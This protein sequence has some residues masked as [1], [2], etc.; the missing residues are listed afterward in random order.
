MITYSFIN[1]RIRLKIFDSN[2]AGNTISVCNAVLQLFISFLFL[3]LSITTASTAIGDSLKFEPWITFE[4]EY[5][6]NVLFGTKNTKDDNITTFSPAFSVKKKTARLNGDITAAVDAVFYQ[7]LDELDAVDKRSSASLSY[8]FTERLQLEMTGGYLEDSRT[9]R[10]VGETGLVFAGDR[11][12]I[13]GGL[14]G[15]YQLSEV[16]AVGISTGYLKEDIDSS[17]QWSYAAHNEQNDTFRANLSFSK[18]ISKLIRNT[19]ALLDISYM[20]YQSESPSLQLIAYSDLPEEILVIIADPEAGTYP[21]IW[22]KSLSESEYDVWNISAGFSKEMT[23]RLSFFIRSGASCVMSDEISTLA[24]ISSD[25]TLYDASYPF[26]GGTTWGWLLFSGVSYKGTYDRIDA[27]ISRDI[28]TASGLNGTTERSGV[29]LKYT[30]SITEKLSARLS[31]SF[32]LNQSDR[33]SRSDID[34][35]TINGGAGMTYNISTVWKGSI[36]WNYTNV[37]ERESDISK[38]R[39]R[40]YA[41]II[42]IFEL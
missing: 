11:E 25:T 8:L 19:S 3:F 22:R 17:D 41:R 13:R 24:I 35:L 1:S 5:S 40:V 21:E 29:S 30:R 38:E 9:D 36:D 26:D 15:Q 42:K 23:E 28:Q 10:E 31:S 39:N 6:D 4:Q 37:E 34:E 16:S 20:N 7:D 33:V 14:S 12:Q 27:D 2:I 32:Y 18:N